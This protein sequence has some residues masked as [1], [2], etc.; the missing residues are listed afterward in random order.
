MNCESIKDN[1]FE[2]IDRKLDPSQELIFKKHLQTCK[3]CSREYKRILDGWK[4]LDLWEDLPPPK[5]LQRNILSSIRHRREPKWLYALVPAAAVLLIITGLVFFYRGAGTKNYNEV[6]VINEAT[7]VRLHSNI[8]AENEAD[9][10]SNLQLLRE[11]EFYDSMDE[12][13]KIDYLPL[14]DDET[15]EDKKE[16]KSS[17]ELLTV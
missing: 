17:L 4:K 1:L 9:I 5:H 15:Q 16:Q 10:I 6:A 3:S 11:K 2:Y 8:T 12:L 13:E 7:P 14:V